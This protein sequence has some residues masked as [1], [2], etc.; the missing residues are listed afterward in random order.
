M[1]YNGEVITE[2]EARSRFQ[3]MKAAYDTLSDPKKRQ[4]YGKQMHVLP[5]S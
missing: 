4:I 1:R 2:D 5:K 3:H